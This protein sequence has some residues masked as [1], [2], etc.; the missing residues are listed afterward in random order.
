MADFTDELAF[1][2][3]IAKE[4]S[5]IAS[6]TFGRRLDRSRKSD[7]SWVTEADRAVEVALR[8]RI[9]QGFPTHNVLGEEGGHR[10]ATGGEPTPGAPTWV[11]DPIDGT[12]NFMSG[13]PI[14]ATLVALR[15]DGVSVLGVAHAPALGETYE[16]ALGSGARCNGEAIEVEDGIDLADATA[17]FASVQSFNEDGLNR[18]FKRLTDSTWRSRGLG[19]FWGHMLVARGAAQIMVEPSLRLWDF[20][21]LE[22]IVSEAG[23]KM[24][25]LA[26]ESCF[27]ESSCIS[28]NGELHSAV[29]GLVDE[30]GEAR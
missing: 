1:A 7:G 4:A 29:L 8:E 5:Q 6:D 17:L 22:P 15:Q 10:N 16:A 26:G 11:L 12:N 3:E 25:T 18:F 30:D 20:A 28:T 21:A 27:D 23:G 19:D 24:T 2:L 13:I 9:G 14:W